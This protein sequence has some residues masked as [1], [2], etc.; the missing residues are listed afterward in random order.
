MLERY[1]VVKKIGEG[2]FGT[3]YLGEHRMLREPVCIKELRAEAAVDPMFRSM[4]LEEA[5]MLWRVHHV[6]LPVLR[7]Y[8]DHPDY[9][10][11]MVMSFIEGDN[12]QKTVSEHGPIDDEHVMWILQ[13]LLGAISY[14]HYQGI[15]HCD[16]K[17]SNVILHTQEHNAVLVDFGLCVRNPGA[18][19]LPKG[20]TEFYIPPEFV[21]G[22][23][24]IPASDI[25]SLGKTALFLSGGDPRTGLPPKDMNRPLQDL[26]RSM[27]LHDSMARP[28][29]ARLLSQQI[30]AIRLK[31]YGRT[32]TREEFKLR[33]R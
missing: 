10:P 21:S 22:L 28:Y 32:E 24:P 17:P 9:R 31:V 6:S 7:D 14:L 33:E 19:T 15:V 20:G 4:F 5:K 1:K 12:L 18:T 13:R 25:Y 3:T 8:I 11:V 23:P 2:S 30:T 29:D 16:I 26:L 27:T